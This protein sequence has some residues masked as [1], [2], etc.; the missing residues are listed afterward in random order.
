MYLPSNVIL[1]IIEETSEDP[2][3]S[4]VEI[5]DGELL[6]EDEL[7]DFF[8]GNIN[9]LP[10]R[11]PTNQVLDEEEMRD[12]QAMEDFLAEQQAAFSST[13]FETKPVSEEELLLRS[14][15]L[16]RDFIEAKADGR[17]Y[18]SISPSPP[19]EVVFDATDSL[20]S[21]VESLKAD[22]HQFTQDLRHPPSGSTPRRFSP[23]SLYS[24]N[25]ANK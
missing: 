19:E 18:D 23:R 22:L 1:F 17:V 8:K 2:L 24:F 7:L 9:H 25:T 21:E 6:T 12:N 10:D 13:K 20:I 16:N 4:P 3:A 15:Q 11:T 14:E 5:H